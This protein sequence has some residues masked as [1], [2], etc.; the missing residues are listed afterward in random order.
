MKKTKNGMNFMKY[1]LGSIVTFL[2]SSEPINAQL[3]PIE[4]GKTYPDVYMRE[5]MEEAAKG[6]RESLIKEPEVDDEIL[7]VKCSQRVL[8][9]I[10]N[11]LYSQGFRILS[12]SCNEPVE[13]IWVINYVAMQ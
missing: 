12:I 11:H 7:T 9:Y 1:L 13:P 8:V 5:A 10:I 6:Y 3:S 4:Q 2:L